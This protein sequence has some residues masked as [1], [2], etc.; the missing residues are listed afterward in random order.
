MKEISSDIIQSLKNRLED[1]PVY[2]AVKNLEDLKIFMEHHVFSVWDYMS[3]IKFLQSVIAPTGCPWV[4]QGDANVKRFINELVM[5]EESDESNIHGEFSSHYELYLVAMREICADTSRCETFVN[6]V[7]EQGINSAL[8]YS[9]IPEPSR[10][11]TTQTFKSIN[12]N[13]PHE[14]AASLAL[15]REHII[16]IMFSCL[17]KKNE[18]HPR[19]SSNFFIIIWKGTLNW[20]ATLMALCHS[21]L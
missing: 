8:V 15:G 4:P 14:V 19:R 12:R 16:P 20:T 10:F 13:K 9:D 1:H 3:L 11:F 5:G 17:L 2:N 21:D 6:N 7:V 18:C